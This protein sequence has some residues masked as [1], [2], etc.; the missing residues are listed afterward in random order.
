MCNC[1][2]LQRARF[3]YTRAR[4]TQRTLC[5]RCEFF[6]DWRVCRLEYVFFV[7]RAH[8]CRQRVCVFASRRSFPCIHSIGGAFKYWTC[9]SRVRCHCHHRSAT[10]DAN[11]RTMM[12]VY[13][14]IRSTSRSV[15]PW[16][17]S[18]WYVN[19]ANEWCEYVCADTMPHHNNSVRTLYFNSTSV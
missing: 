13:F 19:T 2:L 3:A 4:A 14:K 15:R 12:W 10:T 7:L 11:I 6:G 1:V 17:G 16:C 9:S 8:V 18:L 5:W